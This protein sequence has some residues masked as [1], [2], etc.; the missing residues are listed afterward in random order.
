EVEMLASLLQQHKGGDRVLVHCQ[1]ANHE[2]GTI[3]PLEAVAELCRRHGATLHVDAAAAFGHVPT[4]LGSLGAQYVSVSAHKMGGPAGVGALILGPGVRMRPLLVGGSEERARRAGS[5]NL[6]G[7][8]G[9]GAA[10]A[11]LL[12]DGRL[13]E[14]S[15]SASAKRDALAAA[16]L[17]EGRIEVLGP[18]NASLRLPHILCASIDGVLGEAVLLV[19]DRAGIAAHSGSACS[20]EVLEPSPV[21]AAMGFDPDRSLRLSVGWSTTDAD[22]AA[23]AAAWPDAIRSLRAL[24]TP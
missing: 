5:E 20:S 23:F 18:A 22:I 1:W 3:Q 15:R 11:E 21:L 13:E 4:D 16:V 9:F 19:L 7:I 14:E 6:L 8:V 17:S 12:E 2:V 10:A 24:G